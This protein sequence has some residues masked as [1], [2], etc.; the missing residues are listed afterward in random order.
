MVH[1]RS[2]GCG[3]IGGEPPNPQRHKRT[4]SAAPGRAASL[5]R[6]PATLP[7]CLLRALRLGAGAGREMCAGLSLD[8][9][10]R[11]PGGGPMGGFEV[12]LRWVRVQVI[13]EYARHNGNAGILR[14]RIGGVAG[15]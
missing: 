2:A 14:E 8:A 12:S 7:A 5:H 6:G 3:G 9:V 13:E 11:I 4:L 10:G 15:A 1:Q